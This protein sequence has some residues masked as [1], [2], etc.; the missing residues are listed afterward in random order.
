M[1]SCGAWSAQGSRCT[2]EPEHAGCHEA[3]IDGDSRRWWGDALVDVPAPDGYVVLDEGEG[4]TFLYKTP[5][6][7]LDSVRSIL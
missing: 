1:A 2:R 4:Q 6:K 3:L 5:A 7:K